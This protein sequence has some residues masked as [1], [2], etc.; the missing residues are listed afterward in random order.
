MLV[1]SLFSAYGYNFYIRLRCHSVTVFPGCGRY[2]N[3]CTPALAIAADRILGQ[4]SA[5][6]KMGL[7]V[8][9]ASDSRTDRQCTQTNSRKGLSN[10]STHVLDLAYTLKSKAQDAIPSTYTCM[11]WVMAHRLGVE[12]VGLVALT[13][14][15]GPFS[16]L[17]NMEPWA[18]PCS[19]EYTDSVP[20]QPCMHMNLCVLK[21]KG[22]WFESCMQ[23]FVCFF[24]LPATLQSKGALVGHTKVEQ[25]TLQMGH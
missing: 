11:A 4:P 21:V 3:K 23:Q 18:S 24:G 16:H 1:L 20:M 5:I 25:D 14:T 6:V 8:D 22:T 13:R 15:D 9:L 10:F 19:N 12:N 2:W 7:Q 17:G